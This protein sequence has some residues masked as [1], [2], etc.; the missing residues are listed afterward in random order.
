MIY[1]TPSASIEAYAGPVASGLVGS[2][3]VRIM[4]GAGGTALA[5]TTAGIVETPAGSGIYAATLTAPATAGTYA[6]VWDT[7]GGS[8]VFS[9]PEELVVNALGA[10]PVAAGPDLVTLAEVKDLLGITDSSSDTRLGVAIDAASAAIR[11]YTERGIGL[12]TV[13][14]TKTYAYDNSGWLEIEDATAVTSVVL[15]GTAL[16]VSLDYVLGPDRGYLT[17]DAPLVYEW[18][19]LRPGMGQSPYMGFERNLD[20]LLI[21]GR[22]A[23]FS[24]VEVTGDFGFPSVPWDV[25]QAA[26]WTVVEFVTIPEPFSEGTINTYSFNQEK[27]MTDAIP[28]RAKEL[29]APYRRGLH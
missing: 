21:F 19:E 15:D 25:K 5:R 2:I 1:A 22:R 27:A 13:T 6:V 20:T 11:A 4:D 29:L 7:G 17:P 12:A 10:G 24:T 16:T 3:G 23:R 14:T 28:P 9:A 18:I 8:P 26:L